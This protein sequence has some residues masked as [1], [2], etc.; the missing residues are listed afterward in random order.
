MMARPICLMIISRSN[1]LG[2]RQS[3]LLIYVRARHWQIDYFGTSVADWAVQTA[4]KRKSFVPHR[5]ISSFVYVSTARPGLDHGDFLAIMKVAQSNNERLG[6]TGLMLFNGFNFIQCIEGERT[7]TND[8]LHRIGLDDRHSGLTILD[9][10]ELPG[11]QFAQSH[12]AG[13][14]LPAEREQ[15]GLSQLLSNHAVSD[16]TRTYFQSFRSLGASTLG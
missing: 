8:C 12:M 14:F 3:K 16:A 11:R 4:A 7:A 13:H 10:H 2:L 1:D 9:H 15:A 6:I 5:S